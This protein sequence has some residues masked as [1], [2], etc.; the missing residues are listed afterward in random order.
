MLRSKGYVYGCEYTRE[1][2]SGIEERQEQRTLERVCESVLGLSALC[3]VQGGRVDRTAR[4]H[5]GWSRSGRGRRTDV[6][7]A[8]EHQ[9]L[10]RRAGDKSAVILDARREIARAGDAW[11]VTVA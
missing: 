2:H 11:C 3:G 10:K 9:D 4:V 5:S 1:P 6:L 7:A 8:E